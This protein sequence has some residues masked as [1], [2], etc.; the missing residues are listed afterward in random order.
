MVQ[1][2]LEFYEGLPPMNTL[3]LLITCFG[4]T[5]VLMHGSILNKPRNI[6]TRIQFFKELLACSLCTGSWVGGIIG[7]CN[8]SLFTQGILIV[9]LVFASAGFC[10]FFDR[11]LEMIL[12][13]NYKNRDD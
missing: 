3:D 9:Q 2:D 6:I 7:L 10:F 1:E 5:R 8:Y 13:W 11:L 12:T 4:L